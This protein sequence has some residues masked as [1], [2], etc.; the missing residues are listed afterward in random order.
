MYKLFFTIILL[1]CI[2]FI[3]LKSKHNKALVIELFKK[4][5]IVVNGN[6]EQDILVKN[7]KF[8]SE[9][10]YNGELGMAESYMNDYWETRNLY[11]TLFLI[12]KNYDKLSGY[13][14]SLTDIINI[15]FKRIFNYQTIEKSLQDV[16]SHYDIGNDLYIRM[17]DRNMQYTCGYWQDTNDLNTAQLQK[18]KIIGQKLN[19]QPGDTLLDIGCGWG[20]LINY[21]SK[22]FK[23]NGLGITL[24]KEQLQFAKTT[25]ADNKLADY[26]LMDY[27][28]IPNDMKFSKI[29]SVGML[30]HV[31]SK[32]YEE[33]FTIVQN[34]L[35][36]DGIAL[37]H[38][39]GCQNTMRGS[40]GAASK[41]IDKYIFPNGQIPTWDELSS[42]ISNKFYINDWHN[43]GKYY[44]KTLLAWHKNINSKWKEIPHYDDRFIRMWNFYLLGC[45]GNFELGNMLLWQIV[46]T[47]S[48]TRKLP[49]RDC[50]LNY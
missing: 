46:L 41:F 3:I 4:C 44:A 35:K 6:R 20:F 17:L 1:I 43:F 10:I 37:I 12:S 13:D 33:Y 16:Q 34:H 29:V 32:N 27:R 18:M 9:L 36:N 49:R 8:Y 23:I 42:C 40:T 15:L 38:T 25:F 11:Y 50:I 28:N 21:L 7:D 14:F 47:K 5:D 19:L 2:F 45:A 26:K 24:S 31:G 48:S 22:E 30:E 39:I